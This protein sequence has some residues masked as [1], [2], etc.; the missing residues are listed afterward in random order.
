MVTRIR[1]QEALKFIQT[2][3][4]ELKFD[5]AKDR[6]Q[7]HFPQPFANIGQFYD[8]PEREIINDVADYLCWEAR[9]GI[10]GHLRPS[11]D[12]E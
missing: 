3:L 1:L 11:W 9:G 7:A 2:R 6:G 4:R 12:S 10:S 8:I 5:S